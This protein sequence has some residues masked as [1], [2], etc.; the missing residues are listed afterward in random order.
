MAAADIGASFSNY[1]GNAA[2]GGGGFGFERLDVRPIEDLARYTMLYNKS[3]YDQRQKDVEKAAAEIADMTSYDLTSGIP[4]DAKLLQEK[5]D[6][7]TNYVRDNPNALDYRN[8]KEWTAYK[9]MRNDLENDLKGGKVRNTMWALRQKEVQDETDP[10]KKKLLQAELDKEIADT[11]I[12]TP[13]KHTQQYVDN[14]I[15]LPTAPE[16]TFDVTKTGP[17]AVIGRTYSYFNVPKARAN[18]DVFAL[19]MDETVDLSTPQGQRDAIAKKKNFWVQGA[20]A[21]NSVINAKDAAGEFLYKKKITNTATGAVTYTLD[22]SKLSKLPRNILNLIKE[23]NSYL[24]ETKADIKSGVLLDKFE[25]PITFGQGALD[26]NDYTEINY[27]D[28]LSPEELALVAQYAS[29]KGDTYSTKVQQ[30]DNQIQKR[31]QDISAATQRRGQDLDLLNSREG[32]KLQKDLADLKPTSGKTVAEQKAE[33]PILKTDELIESI[34]NTPKAIEDLTP[35]QKSRI[36][37]QM[38][39]IELE[40]AIVSVNGSVI[41]VKTKKDGTTKIQADDITKRYFDDINKIDAG[42][43]NVQRVFYVPPSQRGT[44]NSWADPKNA[45][46]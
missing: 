14:Q 46:K 42:K 7:I 41:T 24:S 37:Q 26:E 2:L 35:E 33:Y 1:Q 18:G 30:T 23:T 40:G 22:E 4:K 3:E 28:G 19:G 32:R 5:Y 25:N 20:E 44:N 36:S 27:E 43:E 10:E 17:N 8:K 38:D 21:F 15:K 39:G 11:D 29:W 12:R 16:L 34:G 9:K 31:G 6:K 45:P 13:I